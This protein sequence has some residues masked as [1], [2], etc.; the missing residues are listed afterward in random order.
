MRTRVTELLGIE[1]PVIQGGMAWVANAD[2]A[3][4]V[5]DA[6]GLGIIASGAAPVEWVEQQILRARELT[7]RPIGVNLMLMNPAAAQIA[8]LL[9]D[10]R[11]EVV[12]TG[13]GNPGAYL[14]AWKA[15]DCKV[16]PV[17]ASSALAKRMERMGADAI[18]CE[19]QEAGGHI[20]EMTTMTLVPKVREA[21]TLPLIAAGGIADGRGMAAAIALGAEGV[22]MGT[23]FLTVDEC[24][25]SDAYKEKVVKAKDVDTIVTGRSS[26]HPVRGLKNPFTRNA[27][28]LEAQYADQPEKLEGIYAGSLHRAVEGDVVNGEMMAGQCACLVTGRGTA[29]QVVDSVVAEAEAILGSSAEALIAMNASQGRLRPSGEGADE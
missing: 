19:G 16:I 13:A 20:G 14:P 28:K 25:I 10:M 7:S 27:K 5:S 15:A 22:Q 26:G 24:T 23:R 6:G 12:T 17:V 21:T 18:I 2:L 1:Q 4:A 29:K 11:V 3:A 9:V 8:Q